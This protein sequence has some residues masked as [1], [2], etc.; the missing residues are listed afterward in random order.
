[1]T[2]QEFKGKW[3]LGDSVTFTFCWHEDETHLYEFD[4]HS[5]VNYDELW[6]QCR[7]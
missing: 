6:E 4:D 5:T 2:L 3:D 7:S 1:M